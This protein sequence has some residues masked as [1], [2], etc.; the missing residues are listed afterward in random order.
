LGKSFSER[1]VVRRF[2]LQH[3][4]F[5]VIYR[6]RADELQIV[7]LAHEKRKPNYWRPRLK[8]NSN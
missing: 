6:E 7:A 5:F 8:I 3:F 1:E 4:P 2:P